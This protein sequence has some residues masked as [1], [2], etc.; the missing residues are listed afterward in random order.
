MAEILIAENE[1]KACDYD[2]AQSIW[3]GLYSA[4]GMRVDPFPPQEELKCLVGAS[5]WNSWGIYAH[6]PNAVVLGGTSETRWRW[7][8]GFGGRILGYHTE[9]DEYFAWDRYLGLRR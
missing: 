3:G 6:Q 4:R 9:C 1:F 2:P 5:K 7:L 8:R